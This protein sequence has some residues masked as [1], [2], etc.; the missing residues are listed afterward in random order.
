MISVTDAG[1]EEARGALDAFRQGFYGAL[2]RR[3]DGLFELADA[4]LCEEGPVRGLAEL[5]LNRAHRRGHGG[6]YAA[7]NHGRINTRRMRKL[8]ARQR[9]P[10]A[11]DGRLMLAVDVSPWLRPDARTCPERLFCHC[12]PRGIGGA[13][14]IPGW[15]Y[16]VVA[17]LGAGR[18]SWTGLLDAVRLGPADDV[19]ATTVAQLRRVIEDL[20]A[21]G[22]HRPGDADIVLVVDAGYDVAYLAH[23]LGDL[24]VVVL[25]RQRSNRVFYHPPRQKTSQAGRP[26]QHGQPLRFRDQHSWSAPD[27]TTT[28]ASDRYGTVTARAWDRMHPMLSRRGA[29]SEHPGPLPVIEGTVILLE[30]EH[31]PGQR[32]GEPL[33]LFVT[34]TGLTAAEV[35]EYWQTFLRRFDLEHTFRFLKQT[36]GWTTPQVRDP[37]AADRWTWLILACYTQLRLARGLVADQ[38]LPWERPLEQEQLSPARVRRG[39]RHIHHTTC[40]PA[41]AP[42]PAKPGPGRPKGRSNTRPTPHHSVGKTRKKTRKRTV[43]DG[44]TTPTNG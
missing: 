40:C 41:A 17:A 36:L 6:L 9:L 10:R 21:A 15:P 8:L 19:A 12:F 31:L 14:L 20:I 3:A 26:A 24:P 33:W 28:T 1:Q 35:N 43:D 39:F 42:K 22:Q 37:A 34:D 5:S 30:P 44:H 25:G 4:A 38:R 16:S 11:E 18:S 32:Q 7:L 23:E 2:P 13:Q 29:W 27:E